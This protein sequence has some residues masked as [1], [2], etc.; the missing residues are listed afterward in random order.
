MEWK[1]F[2]SMEYGKIIFHSI[3]CLGL[4]NTILQDCRCDNIL[5]MCLLPSL[6]LLFFFRK[7]IIPLSRKVERR[8]ARREVSSRANILK[9]DCFVSN[10]Y[11]IRD[12]SVT[13]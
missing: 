2:C 9:R 1:K 4:S 10:F 3:A 6:T 13:V 7:E 8:E 12:M 11:L 5:L